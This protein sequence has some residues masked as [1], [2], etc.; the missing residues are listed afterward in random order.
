MS[1]QDEIEALVTRLD[2]A[3]AFPGAAELR[4]R[5]YRL[6]GL[7]TGARVVD[8]GCGAGRAVAEMT[9]SGADAVGVDVAEPMLRIARR[10]WPG[11][12]F[13]MAGAYTLPFGAGTMDGYRADK[14]YHELG[15]PVR[16]V[17]E[18]RRVLAPSGRIVLVGQDWDTL[19]V[20]AADGALTR[21]I[22]HAR[23]ETIPS[24]RVARRY[25][26]L[27]LDAGFTDVTVEVRTAVLTGAGALPLLTGLADAA[28]AAGAV[29]EEQAAAWA[30]EQT[31]RARTDRLFVAVP[32]F[33]ASATR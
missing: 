2:A 29:T 19:V 8:V 27:L 9:E 6:L 25:R 31:D 22:V 23:A 5:S 33:T 32:M 10:R 17:R 14:V 7:R 11:S 1:T 3:D 30:A 18:A 12:D 20:D 15:D 13:R 28:R 24:P 26:A 4:D 21:A 16:A